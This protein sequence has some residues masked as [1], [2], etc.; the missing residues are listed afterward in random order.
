M[1]AGIDFGTTNSAAALAGPDGA[2]RVVGIP[3]VAALADTMRSLLAFDPEHRDAHRRLIPLVGHEAVEAYLDGGGAVRLLQSFK[4]YLTSRV[5]S[6]A[7]LF[8]ATYS[9]EEMIA[10]VV[11]RL[12][13]LAE[14]EG[15][16][17]LGRVVAGRP[18][19]FVA[20]DGRAEDDFALERLRRAF[21]AAGLDDVVFEYEPIAAACY[22]EQGLTRDETVL[23][24]DFGGGTSDFCLVR[25]GPGRRR[26]GDPAEAILGTD[27]VGLAGD[28]FDRR[29]VEQGLGD[30][31]GRGASFHSGG[32][33]LPVPAW[34]YGKLARWHHISFLKTG[35]TLRMLRD[36]QRHCD[37][38]E[39]IDRLLTLIEADLGYP[40][41]RAVQQVKQ[42]LTLQDEVTLEF[43]QEGLDLSRRI[44]R[45][46][47]E[48]WIAPDLAEMEAAL[49]RLLQVSGVKAHQVDRVFMTGGTSLVPAVRAL[50]ARRFGPGRLEGGGEFVSVATGLAYRARELFS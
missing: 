44:T 13:V 10:L 11:G 16:Q 37:Q 34:L 29:I 20:E 6:S 46:D 24:A 50:F 27:G 38:P 26:R 40:L 31:F 18:V 30:L 8:G 7:A 25:L 39:A 21:A 5:F 12:R 48:G 35:S 1:F 2:A 43:C 36:I 22:Y 19:R 14:A 42:A 45:R 9:L 32:K 17:G 23:V 47:F 28:A 15:G 4:S 33:D 41:Y 49:D 3:A